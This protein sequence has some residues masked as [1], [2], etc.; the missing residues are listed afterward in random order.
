VARDP[1]L[2]TVDIGTN[3]V[4][5]LVVTRLEDGALRAEVERCVITRLG[6]AVDQTGQ[7]APAAV[8]RTLAALR[9]LAREMEEHE[10]SA[11]AAI[12]TAVLRDAE[13]AADFLERAEAALGCPVEVVSGRREAELV[14]RGVRAGLAGRLPASVTLFDVGGGSTELVH[15]EGDEVLELTSLD[16][17][18]VRLTERHL[19]GDPPAAAEVAA[20]RR[21]TAAALESISPAR[22]RADQ[23]VGIAGTV[24][25]LATVQQGLDDYDTDRVNGSH[26]TREQ[27]HTMTRR[28][29][30]LDL[31][32]RRAIVGLE[33]GR[34][35]VILA[36]GLIVTALLDRLG[37]AGL[38]VCDRGVRWGLIRELSGG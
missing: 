9:S 3:S 30:A 33:P 27:I 12:G 16:L 13:D 2:A 31:A 35:D 19:R 24:T 32:A 26:L 1:R 10:V 21:A 28:F 23:V 11:R 36:G 17:G 25:T 6:Q 18:A 29:A 34:A 4:L 22:W 7:L 37:A 15:C 20:L 8:E 38:T 14:L 5:L